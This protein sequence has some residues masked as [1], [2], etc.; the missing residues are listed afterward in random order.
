MG[1]GH[2]EI[3][4]IVVAVLLIFGGR[5]IPELMKGVGSGMREFKKGLRGEDEEVKSINEEEKKDSKA[6]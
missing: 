5:K 4:A 2:W 3:L 6:D 1:L